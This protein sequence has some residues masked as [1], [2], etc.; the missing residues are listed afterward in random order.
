[1]PKGPRV[2]AVEEGV[3]VRT[4]PLLGLS[5]DGAYR[6]AIVN[7]TADL[8]VVQRSIKHKREAIGGCTRTRGAALGFWWRIEPDQALYRRYFCAERRNILVAFGKLCKSLGKYF[9][10]K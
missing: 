7:P 2:S 5:P 6:V 10:R 8:T 1:M 3:A 9:C 4:G